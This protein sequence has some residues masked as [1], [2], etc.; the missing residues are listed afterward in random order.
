MEIVPVEVTGPPVNPVPVVKVVTVPALV[1]VHVGT[2]AP[3]DISTC[4]AVPTPEEVNC[5]PLE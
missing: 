4:P 5:V 1:F 3:P 2:P